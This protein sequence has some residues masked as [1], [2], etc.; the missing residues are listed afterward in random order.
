MLSPTV[1]G[2]EEKRISEKRRPVRLKHVIAVLVPWASCAYRPVSCRGIRPR[3]SDVGS[4]SRRSRSS[5]RAS[6]TE[7][8]SPCHELLS[9]TT[10]RT[11]SESYH[12]TVTT[13]S[14]TP[15]ESYHH[16][17]TTTSRTPSESYHRTVIS[18]VISVKPRPC[19]EPLSPANLTPVRQPNSTAT[20]PLTSTHFPYHRRQA[21]LA[22]YMLSSC[23]R[24]SVRPSVTCQ[25]ST[26]MAKPRITQTTPYGSLGIL[27]Y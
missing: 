2:G 5:G 19:T 13:T 9:S 15:S 7:T 17:V 25:S 11:P 26:K 27:V 20:D 1:S 6:R 14:R 21:M 22:R 4:W 3:C 8:R 12:H 24:L 23:I 16:T 10:S 18:C